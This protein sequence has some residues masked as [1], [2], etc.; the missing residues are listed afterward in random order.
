LST[1]DFPARPHHVTPIGEHTAPTAIY[2]GFAPTIALQLGVDREPPR[3]TRI[4]ITNPLRGQRDHGRAGTVHRVSRSYAHLAVEFDDEPGVLYRVHHDE[5][6][7]LD[8][9]ASS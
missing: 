7:Y 2:D 1:R 4:V 6:S 3:G 8:E 5:A 9:P